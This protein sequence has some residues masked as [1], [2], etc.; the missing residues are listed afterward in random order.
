M[1]VVRPL[2]EA[3]QRAGAPRTP[4]LRAA[5]VT[6]GALNGLDT[7]ISY[8]ALGRLIEAMLELTGDPAF[9]LHCLGRL[10]QRAFNPVSGLVYHAPDK[11]AFHRAF[12]RWTK[13]TP[14]EFGRQSQVTRPAEARPS[15]SRRASRP[16][17]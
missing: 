4:L 12:K 15:R 16:S 2:V 6:P 11:G 1:R 7:R 9:G 13:M 5:G 14:N 8:A 10:S 17:P 3:A